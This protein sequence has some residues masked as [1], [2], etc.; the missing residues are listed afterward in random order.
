MVTN[1][2]VQTGDFL[3]MTNMKKIKQRG[4]HG[5]MGLENDWYRVS[6]TQSAPKKKAPQ[7]GACSNGADTQSRTGD[8]TLTKGALYQLSHI[9]TLICAI[10]VLPISNLLPLK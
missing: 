1:Q 10:S 5:E 4:I 3:Y 6:T 9:S 8:L 7:C 2:T